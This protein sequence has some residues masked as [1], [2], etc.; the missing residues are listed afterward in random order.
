MLESMPDFPAFMKSPLNRIARA[1]QFTDDIEGYVFDGA[2]GSQVA[3]W[4]GAAARTSVEHTHEYDE[5]I[6][7]VE[8]LVTVI[9]D[10]EETVL[11]AGDELVIPKGTKQQVSTVAG[12]RTIHVFGGRRA[13]RENER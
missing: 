11:R 4:T 8:G 1:S 5:Y 13:R 10:T 9:I 7:V 12:T 6:L 2:D 3:F